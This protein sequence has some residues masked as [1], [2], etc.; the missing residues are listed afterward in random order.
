MAPTEFGSPLQSR[1]S[2]P[3]KAAAGLLRAKPLGG[4][5]DH[6]SL[7]ARSHSAHPMGPVGDAD[8]S[9]F[10]PTTFLRAW[11]FSHVPPQARAQHY[12]ETLRPD[13]TKLREYDLIAVDREI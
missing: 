10:D 3:V 1:S 9:R 5:Q 2:R 7:E 6:T 13:G 11:N 8:L 12:R 4:E